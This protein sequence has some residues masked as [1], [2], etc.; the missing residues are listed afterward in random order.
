VKPLNNDLQ[1]RLAAVQGE[2]A[3][4]EEFERQLRGIL[5]SALSRGAERAVLELA[6]PITKRLLV[7]QERYAHQ[8]P[9]AA[10][11]RQPAEVLSVRPVSLLAFRK[12][13]PLL[14]ADLPA[15]LARRRSGGL[16]TALDQELAATVL[17]VPVLVDG[18]AVGV[19]SLA[20]GK[21]RA[22][23]EAERADLISYAAIAARMLGGRRQRD[24]NRSGVLLVVQTLLA[25]VE[26]RDPATVEH[27]LRV[28]ECAVA[29]GAAFSL[30][31]PDLQTLRYAALLHDLGKIGLSDRLLK[32]DRRLHPREY[33]EVKNY[34]AIGARILSSV[35]E[36]A[37][38]SQAVLHHQEHWDGSGYPDGLRGEAIPLAARI[39]KVA[40]AYDAITSTRPYRQARGT[41]FAVREIRKLA[42]REFCPR[43][44]EVFVSA[45]GERDLGRD[46]S[47]AAMLVGHL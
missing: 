38:A 25:A 46:E 30:S 13:T 47:L 17:S 41:G 44:V 8:E 1:V 22:F 18:A 36:L 6:D 33:E 40:D 19:L 3:L 23:G 24:R 12:Q 26:A 37:A 35:P 34:P 39:V 10:A 9:E 31:L 45:V 43:V 7:A 14:L 32:Q 27:L 29:I 11:G 4:D 15:L 5:T 16:R 21:P 20:S 28:E 42:G 2:F